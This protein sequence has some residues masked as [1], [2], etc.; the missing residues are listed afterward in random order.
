MESRFIPEA[1]GLLAEYLRKFRVSAT[2]NEEEFAH[3]FLPKDG[4][5][6]AYVVEVL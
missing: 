1:C 3:W 5:V 6:N 2:F 4:I